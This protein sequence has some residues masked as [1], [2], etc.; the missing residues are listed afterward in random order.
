MFHPSLPSVFIGDDSQNSTPVPNF[1]CIFSYLCNKYNVKCDN[2]SQTILKGFGQISQTSVRISHSGGKWRGGRTRHA[3]LPNLILIRQPAEEP[4]LFIS[5]FWRFVRVGRLGRP[6]GV[7]GLGLDFGRLWSLGR[8]EGR[9]RRR[10]GG[11]FQR[12]SRRGGRGSGEGREDGWFKRTSRSIPTT[13]I[14]GL[15]VA[16]RG[17]R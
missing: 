10:S 4:F 5:V 15:S 1:Y 14:R 3:H 9:R 2:S 17:G 16:C 13:L 11:W 6:V 7:G 12:F 8:R